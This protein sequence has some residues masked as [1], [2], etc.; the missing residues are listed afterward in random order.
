MTVIPITQS[1][2]DVAMAPNSMS[3]MIHDIST[4]S[5]AKV[6]TRGSLVTNS[7]ITQIFRKEKMRSNNSDEGNYLL[8]RGILLKVISSNML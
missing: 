7:R 3:F 1:L 8:L 2:V 6:L 4:L 5:R